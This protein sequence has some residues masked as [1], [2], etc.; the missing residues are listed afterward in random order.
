MKGMVG[1]GRHVGRCPRPRR[2]VTRLDPGGPWIWDESAEPPM[3]NRR[4]WLEAWGL[5]PFPFFKV[6][7]RRS[8]SDERKAS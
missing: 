5:T 1:E 6:S 7:G 3:K 2:K 4:G 8:V